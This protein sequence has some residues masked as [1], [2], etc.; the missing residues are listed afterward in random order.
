[1]FGITTGYCDNSAETS[2]ENRRPQ[3]AVFFSGRSRPLEKG[4]ADPEIR[5]EGGGGGLKKKI[6]LGSQFGL[7]IKGGA[8]ESFVLPL[9]E[10]VF[11]KSS[12]C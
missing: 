4:G 10:Y 6:L 3:I 11:S 2:R 7:K 8:G 1:M 9:T 5:G 12:T